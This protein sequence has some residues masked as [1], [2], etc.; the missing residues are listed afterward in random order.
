MNKIDELIG[1]CVS[2]KEIMRLA[3]ERHRNRYNFNRIEADI[4]LAKA[5]YLL[6]ERYMTLWK[7]PLALWHLLLAAFNVE[8]A[9]ESVQYKATKLSADQLHVASAILAKAPRWLGGNTTL[10]VNLIDAALQLPAGSDEIKRSTRAMLFLTKRD[11]VES[12]GDHELAS[13]L[14]AWAEM[15]LYE[16]EKEE[17]DDQPHQ[18]ILVSSE[19]GFFYVQHAHP[20][21]EK[22]ALGKELIAW[23]YDASIEIGDGNQQKKI[24]AEANRLGIWK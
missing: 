7:M 13:I 4:E 23:A 2:A 9:L 6:V 5:H 11:I 3:R 1:G 16:M 17:Y 8:S 24:A 22:A 12:W 19:V 10:A 15:L 21:S 18:L 20:G 14:N